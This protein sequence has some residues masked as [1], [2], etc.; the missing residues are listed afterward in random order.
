MRGLTATGRSLRLIILMAASEV[1][2]VSGREQSRQWE[3]LQ[4]SKRQNRPRA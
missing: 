4:A 3:D 1:E 2:W